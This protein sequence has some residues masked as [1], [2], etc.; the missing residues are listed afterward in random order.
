[1]SPCCCPLV[2]GSAD[3]I[4][5]TPV[6]IGALGPYSC[7]VKQWH[8]GDT[9]PLCHRDLCCCRAGREC[10]THPGVEVFTFQQ[11]RGHLSLTQSC[12]QRNCI[13][14]LLLNKTRFHFQTYRCLRQSTESR[15]PSLNPLSHPLSSISPHKTT[16]LPVLLLF[17]YIRHLCCFF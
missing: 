17:F 11:A 12:L 14:S 2:G 6:A 15:S 8:G 7:L 13:A 5:G 1:M 16:R 9:V 4:V 3:I 10:P